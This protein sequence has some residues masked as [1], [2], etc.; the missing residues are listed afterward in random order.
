MEQGFTGTLDHLDQ[1]LTKA[2][3]NPRH[4]QMKE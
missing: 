4:L 3:L 1:Y 2:R